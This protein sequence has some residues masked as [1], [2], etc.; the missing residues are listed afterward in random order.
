VTSQQDQDY[1]LGPPNG[2]SEEPADTSAGHAFWRR[3]G[4]SKDTEA[5]PGTESGE[6]DDLAEPE[7]AEAKTDTVAEVGTDAGTDTDADTDADADTDTEAESAELDGDV[8]VADPDDVIVADPGDV[9][10]AEV[11]EEEPLQPLADDAA[12]APVTPAPAT[13]AD[14][15]AESGQSE[16]ADTGPIPMPEAADTGLASAE[17]ATDI[18]QP[19]VADTGQPDAAEAGPVAGRH[20]SGAELGQEWRDIQAAFVD[21]PRGAV[22][23]AAEATDAAMSSLIDSLRSRRDALTAGLGDP[24]DHRDTEQ[25]RGELRQYRM[26]CQNLAEIEQRLARPQSA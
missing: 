2:D 1:E 13:A 25:L 11:I 6:A 22:G 4:L 18:G 14:Q 24:S 7:G 26:L 16:A 20:A 3:V 9:I 10:V 15:A 23:M 17:P 19:Q 8:I 12:E 5:E 21:D